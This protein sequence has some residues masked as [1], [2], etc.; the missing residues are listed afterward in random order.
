MGVSMNRRDRDLLSK[1]LRWLSPSSRNDGV[2][3][4]AIV[5]AFV[6]GI[7]LGALAAHK[8]D[9]MQIVSSDAMAAISL[10]DAASPHTF[11]N[12]TH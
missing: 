9:L 11:P 8:S 10:P 6:A 7:S 4:C 1:Q 12:S 5:A 3:V 2:M